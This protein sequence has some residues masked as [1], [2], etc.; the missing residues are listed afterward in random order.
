MNNGRA[1]ER[2]AAAAVELAA[3]AQAEGWNMQPTPVC[4]AHPSRFAQALGLRV[5]GQGNKADYDPAQLGQYDFSVTHF[6]FSNPLSPEDGQKFS[7]AL[8][9]ATSNSTGEIVAET[10]NIELRPGVGVRPESIQPSRLA[11]AAHM[12]IA[13]KIVRETPSPN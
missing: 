10:A 3:S 11:F 9:Y 1:Q 6:D 5:V 13:K 4:Y 2:F 8:A 12:A 7:V